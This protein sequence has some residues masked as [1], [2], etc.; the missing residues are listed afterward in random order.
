MQNFNGDLLSLPTLGAAD[1]RVA[2]YQI[3]AEA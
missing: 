2:S 1:S 3:Q